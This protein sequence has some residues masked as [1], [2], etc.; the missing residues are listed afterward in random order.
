MI[1][2]HC[3]RHRRVMGGNQM[4]MASHE[5]DQ[6][7]RFFPARTTPALRGAVEPSALPRFSESGITMCNNPDARGRHPAIQVMRRAMCQT[8]HGLGA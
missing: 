8:M 5:F 4:S 7:R 2:A 6:D 3:G 1:A